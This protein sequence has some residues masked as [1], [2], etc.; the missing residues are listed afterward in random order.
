MPELPEVE[1]A[2]RALGR[3]LEGRT[4]ERASAPESRIVR[5]AD[6][7]AFE[8]DLQGRTLRR[9]DRRGKILLLAFDGDVGLVSHLGMTGKW[10]RRGPDDPRPRHARARLALR[11]DGIVYYDDQRLFGRL[12][13]HPAHS[14]LELPEV[15][16]LGPDPLVDGVDPE[17]L[18][19]R[20]RR[21][22]RSVKVA[23]MDQSVLAG[24]GN[25][26]ATEALFRAG[27]H[28]A[29]VASTLDLDE[30][31]ALAAGIE[32]SIAHTLG[33]AGDGD[34]IAYVEEPGAA[35]P[36]LVYGRKGEPCP[37]C[38]TPIEAIVLGGRTSAFCPRCQKR[39]G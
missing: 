1:F 31:R 33:D 9:I 32:D 39:S 22:S 19:E 12:A 13:V 34:E 6:R 28:P 25:I 5:G 8:R 18:L 17:R 10:V 4:I 2:A 20:L 3:W 7:R 36:F 16:A 35:N 11:G 38:G 21:T 37:R 29:R 26:Q 24:L 23:I 15:R 30:V 14:L 27:I